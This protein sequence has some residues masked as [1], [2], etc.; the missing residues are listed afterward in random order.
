M[1]MVKGC[2][3]KDLLLQADD[4]ES[5]WHRALIGSAFHRERGAAVGRIACVFGGRAK[6]ETRCHCHRQALSTR[7]EMLEVLILSSRHVRLLWRLGVGLNI[8]KRSI[9]G[10]NRAGDK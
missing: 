5:E 4:L 7:F 8:P 1:E 3:G 9:K 6:T 2:W 10:W